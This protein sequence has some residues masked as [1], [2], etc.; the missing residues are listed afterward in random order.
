MMILLIGVLLSVLLKCH[1]QT[2]PKMTITGEN[3]NAETGQTVFLNCVISDLHLFPQLYYNV[4]WYK[5][6]AVDGSNISEGSQQ[7]TDPRVDIVKFQSGMDTSRIVY[8]LTITNASPSHTSLYTCQ[9]IYSP[10]G[11]ITYKSLS[12]PEYVFVMD[13]F[14]ECSMRVDGEVSSG[15]VPIPV[16]S[17]VEFYCSAMM[18]SPNYSLLWYYSVIDERIDLLRGNSTRVDNF[19]ESSATITANKSY[20]GSLFLCIIWN[21][22]DT[23]INYGC[24]IGLLS[25][26]EQ[27]QTTTAPDGTDVPK[28]GGMTTTSNG[29]GIITT[30]NDLNTLQTNGRTPHPSM[31][32]TSTEWATQ[33]SNI[34]GVTTG[35]TPILTSI[36]I[37]PKNNGDNSQTLHVVY[38][39]PP[40]VWVAIGVG[41]IS[42]IC[43]CVVC[44]A[45]IAKWKNKPETRVHD[46]PNHVNG[47]I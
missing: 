33:A 2:A 13:K 30:S 29:G 26:G 18:G 3:L 12:M 42:F 31:A 35:P 46:T 19:E 10:D 41:G 1:S 24:S 23:R 14:P 44:I 17:D 28:S 39:F 20:N 8:R 38:T 27:L 37:T 43:C 32:T 4:R 11:G 47:N 6:T 40:L 9:L 45:I 5:G 15:D 36:Q 22:V 25:I 16:G 7:N 21:S 34:T